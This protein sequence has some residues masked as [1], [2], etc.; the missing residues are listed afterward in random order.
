M[1][2]DERVKDVLLDWF[3]VSVLDTL[4]RKGGEQN[5]SN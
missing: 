2:H 4:D 5:L 3:L 1:V